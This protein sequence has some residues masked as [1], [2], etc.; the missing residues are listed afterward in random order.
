M[1]F[2][3]IKLNHNA[4]RIDEIKTTEAIKFFFKNSFLQYKRGPFKNAI[5][6]IKL[7]I[8]NVKHITKEDGFS[9]R[10]GIHRKQPKKSRQAAKKHKAAYP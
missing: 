2:G 7:I 10:V 3:E 5:E 4:S 8:E 1:Y 9:T 6:T